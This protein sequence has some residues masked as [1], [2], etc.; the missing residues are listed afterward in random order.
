MRGHTSY[1]TFAVKSADGDDKEKKE[2]VRDED[3]SETSNM[4]VV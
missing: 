1:L 3:I 4:D 2:E